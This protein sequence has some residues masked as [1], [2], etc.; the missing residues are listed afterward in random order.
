V[1][2]RDDFVDKLQRMRFNFKNFFMKCLAGILEG[3]YRRPPLS[4]EV[5]L[6]C[7]ELKSEIT[8][9]K[10]QIQKLIENMLRS[11]SA[12]DAGA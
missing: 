4:V 6:K 3:L 1:R 11:D 12:F 9:Q 8:S 2:L 10:A 7:N 5:S